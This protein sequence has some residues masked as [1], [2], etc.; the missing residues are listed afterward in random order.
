MC[1]S[2]KLTGDTESTN[3][4]I[5]VEQISEYDS[6][7]LGKCF[8]LLISSLGAKNKILYLKIGQDSF[9]SCLQCSLI[10]KSI[11]PALRAEV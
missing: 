10:C 11:L 2:K 5:T 7:Y 4:L 3:L 1:I 6:I 9:S 8:Q